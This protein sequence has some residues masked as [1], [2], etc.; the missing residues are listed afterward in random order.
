VEN[1]SGFLLTVAGP[2]RCHTGFPRGPGGHPKQRWLSVFECV[3]DPL[4]GVNS[5][6]HHASPLRAIRPWF[7]QRFFVATHSHR[8][9]PKGGFETSK[10]VHDPTRNGYYDRDDSCYAAA[11]LLGA[12][13]SRPRASRVFGPWRCF[14]SRSPPS[15]LGP[16]VKLTVPSRSRMPT[17]PRR[18]RSARL[19]PNDPCPRGF[20]P[21]PRRPLRRV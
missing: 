6:P 20:R 13:R 11:C 16:K 3:G 7:R 9:A 5:S 19:S 18:R 15:M 1:A 8:L 12:S 10:S 14:V 4:G 2:R 17:L 21:G